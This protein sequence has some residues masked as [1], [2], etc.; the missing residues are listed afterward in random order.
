MVILA[1]FSV[2]CSMSFRRQVN[3]EAPSIL[4]H[5]FPRQLQSVLLFPNT[6]VA[7]LWA[8]FAL[9]LLWSTEVTRRELPA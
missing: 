2:N 5:E 1:A 7:I 3:R 6:S 9:E 8:L 4:G